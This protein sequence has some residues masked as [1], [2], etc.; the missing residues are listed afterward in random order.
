[1]ATR[2]VTLI[3][4]PVSPFNGAAI[5]I[6]CTLSQSHDRE[7]IVTEHPV[8]T[9]ASVSDS[10]RPQPRRL[11]LSGV[12]TTTPLD[13]PGRTEDVDD[14]LHDGPARMSYLQTLLETMRTRGQ[15][16]QVQT[17]LDLYKNMALR[18]LRFPREPG[19]GDNL[20]FSLDLQEIVFATAQTVRVPGSARASA[21]TKKQATTRQARGRRTTRKPTAAEQP[22]VTHVAQGASLAGRGPIPQ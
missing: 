18:S 9:G 13:W 3:F 14:G 12:Q 17:G 15:V 2:G 6:D 1:M 22:R 7:A 20:F 5:Q 10:I 19:L 4:P 16:I 8:E 21:K 11:S